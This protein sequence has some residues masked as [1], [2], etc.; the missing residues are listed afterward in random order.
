MNGFVAGTL[1]DTDKGLIPVQDLKVGD[2][3]SVENIF[4]SIDFDGVAKYL[5]DLNNHQIKCYF[6]KHLCGDD[7][8]MPDINNQ[9]L[10]D[11]Y[12]TKLSSH[13]EIGNKN[14]SLV[15]EF[16][17]FYINRLDE[18]IANLVSHTIEAEN[19]DSFFVGNQGLLVQS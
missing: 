17:D 6:V 5:F 2:L 9:Y 13:I 3:V 16:F 1:V 10:A 19:S 4:Y 18:K 12:D 15:R 11:N 8:T 14:S 7:F